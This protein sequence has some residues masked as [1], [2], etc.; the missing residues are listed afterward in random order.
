[1][2]LKKKTITQCHTFHGKDSLILILGKLILRKQSQ[3]MGE[4]TK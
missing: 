3:F 2:N 1:M 4:N